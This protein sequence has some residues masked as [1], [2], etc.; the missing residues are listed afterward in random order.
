MVS[1]EQIGKTII[2][3]RKIRGLSQERFALESGIDRRYLS[4]IEN[5]KRNVS[6]ELLNR[7]ATYFK[8]SLSRFIEEAELFVS[9]KNIGELRE[10][11]IERGNED[12]SFFSNPDF[13]DA[14]LGIN[15]DGCLVYSYSKMLESLMLSNNMS[16]EEAVEFIEYNTLRT[17]PYMGEHAP[18]IVYNL[19]D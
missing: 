11:L 4:D 19:I 12:T 9:F 8:I 1:Q 17:I 15:E 5:G 2:R 7:V 10:F 16:Y 6:F 13:L 3:L 18:I 14:I